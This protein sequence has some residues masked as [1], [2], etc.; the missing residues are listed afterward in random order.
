MFVLKG[1]LINYRLIPLSSTLESNK[2]YIGFPG[3]FLSRCVA[4]QTCLTSTK[5]CYCLYYRQILRFQVNAVMFPLNFCKTVIGAHFKILHL[6]SSTVKE[7]GLIQKQY[8]QYQFAKLSMYKSYLFS[9]LLEIGIQKHY[10]KHLSNKIK[11]KSLVFGSVLCF[12]IIVFYS[13]IVSLLPTVVCSL[14]G[15]RNSYLTVKI[16][17]LISG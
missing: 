12:V 7:P 17:L 6:L 10:I 8:F 16:I 4:D 14:K 3:G 2:T 9:V 13:F 11:T 15:S 1:Q 5:L